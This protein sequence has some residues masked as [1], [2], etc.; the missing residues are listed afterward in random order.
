METVQRSEYLW[1]SARMKYA[2]YT[3]ETLATPP[4][5]VQPF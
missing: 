5:T 2:N 1:S 4:V 3:A